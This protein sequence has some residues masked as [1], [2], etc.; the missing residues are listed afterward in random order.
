MNETPAPVDLV[1]IWHF[2]QP[3]YRAPRTRRAEMPWVRLHATKDYLDMARHA[4]RHPSVRLAFNFVPVLLDQLE[5][6]TH[7]EPDVLFDRIRRPVD[8]WSGAEG[9]A[10]ARE[11]CRAPRH[12]LE[13]QPTYR[14]LVER[15][16]RRAA[17]RGAEA[18]PSAEE[19]IDLEVGF[20]LAW[21]DPTLQDAP[22]AARL[23]ERGGFF[24]L[25]D[26]DD[27]LSLHARLAAEVI[28]AYQALAE[29]GQVE[30]STTAYY[31]PILPLLFDLETAHRARPDL[32]LPTEPLRAPEDARRQLERAIAR[33]TEVFGGMPAGLWPAEGSVSPEVAEL[34]AGCGLRWLASDEGVLWASLPERERR[35]EL[36]YRPWILPTPA[37]EIALLFRDHELSDRIGFVYQRWDAGQAA[38]DFVQRVRRIARE[39]PGS[40]PPVVTVILDGENCWEGYAD[41]GAAFLDTLYQMLEA[42]PEIHMR[43]PSEAITAAAD[44]GRLERLHSGS[45]IDADFHVWIGH[46][47]KNRAWEL[48]GRTRRSLVQCGATPD[49][50]PAAWEPLLR[51]EGSDW[52]WWYGDDHPSLDKDTF[53]RLFRE[54]LQAAYEAAGLAPPAVL[55]VPIG[56]QRDPE[57]HRRPL[58]LVHPVVD[59]RRT[60]FYEW[61]AAGRIALGAGGGTMHH[62]AGLG[63]ELYY[64]FDLE[65]LHLRLDF[66]APEPPGP[67]F[68]LRLEFSEPHARLETDGL[69]RGERVVCRVAGEAG[70][71]PIEG[72][73]CRVESVLELAVPFRALGLK[74]G[75]AVELLAQVVSDGKPIESLPPDDLIRFAVPDESFEAQMWTA[76]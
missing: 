46:P 62:G 24:T 72:A 42:A 63:R 75:D 4:G 1:L 33:H 19:L 12:A 43:T 53:D 40:A 35:R 68:R 2:H 76:S 41:D 6:A 29:R 30:L 52:F 56:R 14:R 10:L 31:H 64:G 60:H 38:A 11:L 9:I 37:G 17:G 36:L 20:L 45:W 58:G 73:S 74:P 34:A 28:P 66:A 39:H 51:A 71:I 47:E 7:G 22:E 21:L 48:I 16:Q 49:S 67:E 55:Q 8:S 32:P 25:A 13:R 23:L 15:I 3:D 5:G 50:H 18:G 61:Y 26:R 70:E 65:R 44:V 59:G 57:K 54:Q 27:L 69:M